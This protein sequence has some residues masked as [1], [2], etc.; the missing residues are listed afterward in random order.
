MK[1]H[2]TVAVS[3]LALGALSG[4]SAANLPCEKSSAQGLTLTCYCP[5]N[6]QPGGTG[7]RCVKIADDV[8]GI[9]VY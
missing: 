5:P 4:P 2:L 9:D 1:K 3:L 6:V 7:C 8:T